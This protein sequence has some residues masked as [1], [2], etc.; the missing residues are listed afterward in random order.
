MVSNGEMK[1][2]GE[3]EKETWKKNI[4]KMAAAQ[5]ACK[6]RLVRGCT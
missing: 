1:L 3:K 4:R 5:Q 2:K 6:P